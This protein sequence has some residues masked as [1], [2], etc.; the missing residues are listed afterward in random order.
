MSVDMIRKTSE[1]NEGFTLLEV[2]VSL[3][4]VMIGVLATM[5]LQ[6]ISVRNNTSGN[7]ATQGLMLAQSKIE[8]IKSITNVKDLPSADFPSPSTET[9][10]QGDGTDVTDAADFTIDYRFCDPLSQVLAGAYNQPTQFQG[11]MCNPAITTA[12]FQD[13]GA[14]TPSCSASTSGT[15]LAAVRVMWTRA[16]NGR[17][18][19]GCVVL[20]T[21]TQ[22]RGI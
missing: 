14:G 5:G 1:K 11:D 12:N 4:I 10:V 18:G 15:C 6:F 20:Q 8:Q 22:G 16:T 19:Q 9:V 17:G 21:I 7:V 2:L 13:C 3:A